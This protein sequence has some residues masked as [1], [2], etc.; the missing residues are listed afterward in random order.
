[1]VPFCSGCDNEPN[2]KDKLASALDDLYEV[3][4]DSIVEHEA[5]TALTAKR[6]AVEAANAQVLRDALLGMLTE[7][8]RKS[9]QHKNKWSHSLT[10]PGDSIGSSAGSKGTPATVA[11]GSNKKVQSGNSDI[12]HF[13]ELSTERLE[14][15]H[16]YM[17]DSKEE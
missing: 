5:A 11:S 6:K 4:T 17:V 3:V 9:I 1:M 12:Q 7:K 14:S 13:I 8:K 10:S 16:I 2:S 15:H